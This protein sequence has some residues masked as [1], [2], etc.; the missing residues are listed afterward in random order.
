[1]RR[2]EHLNKKGSLSKTHGNF[3]TSVFV[4]LSTVIL[5]ARQGVPPAG[6]QDQPE[7]MRHKAGRV[8]RGERVQTV[9][10]QP[11]RASGLSTEEQER[12]K[13]Q[14]VPRE[15]R[16]VR[17]NFQVGGGAFASGTVVG[18]DKIA[19][20]PQRVTTSIHSDGV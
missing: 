5:E 8:Q 14:T 13:I 1:M 6:E 19:L 4:S 15:R 7:A 11:R 2:V 20:S 16:N 12:Q 9:A 18:S 3:R 17:V 10:E